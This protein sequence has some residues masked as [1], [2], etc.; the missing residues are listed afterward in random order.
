MLWVRG[1]GRRWEA[2]SL[3]KFVERGFVERGAH[4]ATSRGESTRRR[5]LHEKLCERKKR[6]RAD[7]PMAIFITHERPDSGMCE[8]CQSVIYKP[9]LLASLFMIF[10]LHLI[11]LCL[12]SLTFVTHQSSRCRIGAVVVISDFSTGDRLQYI[13]TVDIDFLLSDPPPFFLS[14]INFGLFRIEKRLGQI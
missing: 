7:F 1:G 8:C 9:F 6:M 12:L 13:Y 5:I 10:F 4:S 14:D 3:G 2:S 11:F